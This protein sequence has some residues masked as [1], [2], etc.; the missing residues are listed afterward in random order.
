MCEMF[1]QF[2][3]KKREEKRIEE[4]QAAKAQNWKLPVCY[5]DNDDEER[6]NS[7]EDNI[8]SGLSSCVAITPNEPVDSLSTGDE[9]LDTISAMESDEFIKSCVKNLVPNPSESEGE[10]ECDMPASEAFTTFSNVLFDADYEFDSVDGHSCSDEEVLEKIFLNPL[11]EEKIISMKIDQHHFNA[12]SDLLESLLNHD[13]SI[14][15]SSSKI[16]SLLNEFAGK[17]TLLKSIPPGIDKTDCYH[18][19]EICFI[20]RL[21]MSS[22]NHLTSDIKDAFSSRNYTLASPDY[23]SASLGNT[24]SESLNNPYG[25]V[26]I[27]MPPKRTS[28]S[29]APTMNQAT[30]RQLI[31]DRVVA[32]LEAQAANMENI[33]NTNRNPEQAHVARKCSYKEFMSCQPFN[34]RGS[35]GALGLIRW[36]ERTESVFSCS[37][38]TEDCKVKFATGTLTEEALSWWNSFAQPIGME[39]AYKITWVEFKKLLI[40][41]YCPRTEVQKIEDEFYHLTVKRNDL[42]TYVRRF[43]ELETLC[44]T[45]VSDSEKMMEAFI[46]GLP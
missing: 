14:I 19:N 7:L 3:Q 29:A 2:V 44:P 9:H 17:L 26:P 32:A 33:D 45:M 31:D 35:K 43:Q 36:F 39:E 40:K 4:E 38:C 20:E 27:A 24:P 22:P 11:F 18:E 13:S 6:S 42:K 30:I 10:S 34:F 37:N 46:G 21:V 25:L 28:T 41:K 1:C 5:D 16:D 15:P 23:S 12:E 8:I